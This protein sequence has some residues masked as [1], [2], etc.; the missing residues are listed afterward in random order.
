MILLLH[1]NMVG[2][3]MVE[4]GRNTFQGLNTSPFFTTGWTSS[5]LESLSFSSHVNCIA[6]FCGAKNFFLFS[7]LKI[8]KSY[9]YM[10]SNRDGHMKIY[11]GNWYC[12]YFCHMMFLLTISH[13]L[14]DCKACMDYWQVSAVD[15]AGV[16]RYTTISS[17]NFWRILILSQIMT[18]L[19]FCLFSISF[20]VRRQNG[21]HF[22]KFKNKTPMTYCCFSQVNVC[23]SNTI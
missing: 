16:L 5:K 7:H 9:M 8:G 13:F 3:L 17:N 21:V 12:F 15:N 19:L 14:N 20:K 2:I 1:Y 6:P 23:K 11:T 18:H 22:S 4:T 10:Y